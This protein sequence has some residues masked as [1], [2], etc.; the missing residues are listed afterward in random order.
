MNIEIIALVITVCV[1]VSVLLANP[2]RHIN[3]AFALISLFVA[4]WLLLL[5]AITRPDR[6]FDPVP[7]IKTISAVGAFFPWLLWWLGHCIIFPGSK[8]RDFFIR[9]KY[10][11]L[12]VGA[13]ATIASSNWFI[14]AESTRAKPLWGPGAAVYVVGLFFCYLLFVSVA[15]FEMRRQKGIHQVEI[16]TLL[17]GGA[18]SCFVG[19][20]ITML[21]PMLRLPRYHGLASLAVLFFYALSAWGITSRKILDAQQLFLAVLRRAVVLVLASAFLLAALNYATEVLPTFL[22]MI[23]GLSATVSLIVLIERRSKWPT[24]WGT[25]ESTQQMRAVLLAAAREEPDPEALIERY[26]TILREWGRTSKARIR[27]PDAPGQTSNPWSLPS[28]G[29]GLALLMQE[30][31]ATPES[32]TRRRATPAVEELDRFM[33]AHQLAVIVLS[34]ST[35]STMPISIGLGQR[36]DKMPFLWPQ[37]ERLL[38]W[39]ELIEVAVSRAQLVKHARETEQVATAGLLGASLAHEIRNPLVAL[40]TFAQLL[41]ERHNDPEFR[42]EFSRLLEKEVGRI[43]GLTEQLMKL[44]TPRKPVLRPVR[45]NQIVLDCAG[46]VRPKFSEAQAD[47][48]LELEKQER[49]I[50]ADGSSISQ[51][52]LNLLVNAVQALTD[53][54]GERVVTV[55]TQA[56]PREFVLEVADTGP[57]VAAAQRE[58][59]FRPFSSGKVNGFGLGLALSANIM[60]LH[61][62]TITLVE[63]ERPG[64][65]FRLIFPCPP[66]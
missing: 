19:L 16:R 65:T 20:C 28:D 22:V 12:T 43:A 29:P 57:G 36:E 44:S 49:A 26:C 15:I 62:G 34:P 35:R 61:Q 25:K 13:L 56:R 27:L 6:Y 4:V 24:L 10:W 11:L 21:P 18:I 47:L 59:L 53:H 50:S 9:G 45:L 58:R 31:W 2:R 64:A 66:I 55:R 52:V 30:R 37:I 60:R 23:L 33:S 7:W 46:L 8:W 51:V 5:W 3:Q 14:P 32:L 17:I 42:A 38:E 54:P 39:S 41:P 1:G 40:K 63:T 48:V